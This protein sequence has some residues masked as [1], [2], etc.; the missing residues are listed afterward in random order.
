MR[1]ALATNR[2]H[3]QILA[4]A[5]NGASAHMIA[6]RWNLT[7]EEASTYIEAVAEEVKSHSTHHRIN[8]RH[9]LREQVAGAIKTLQEINVG[10]RVSRD[11]AGREVR[12]NILMTKP[13]REAASVRLKAADALLKHSQRF[14]DEDVVRGWM[15][16]N[17]SG[18]DK[19]IFD[20]T[21]EIDESGGITQTV[22]PLLKLVGEDD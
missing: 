4:A 12:E 13:D 5:R 11:G 20:F 2:D 10:Y 7:I 18:I 21:C 1:R 9:L 17:D 14:L 16:R 19:T 15:E 3:D 22:K 8:L 6:R